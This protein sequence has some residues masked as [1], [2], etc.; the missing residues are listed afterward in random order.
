MH[1]DISLHCKRHTSTF[2]LTKQAQ[3]SCLHLTSSGFIST[4]CPMINLVIQRV[5][6]DGEVP[7]WLGIRRMHRAGIVPWSISVA[8]EDFV[9]IRS[10]ISQLPSLC[11][12]ESHV[13][14]FTWSLPH[15]EGSPVLQGIDPHTCPALTG[16]VN[17]GTAHPCPELLAC[18]ASPARTSPAC[19]CAPVRCCP[20][21]CGRG[22]QSE[23]GPQQGSLLCHLHKKTGD[24][25][26]PLSP[27]PVFLC[28]V[29]LPA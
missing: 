22:R 23:K 11:G 27:A 28:C 2:P 21:C 6:R 9:P 10:F 3:K 24:R 15:G 19:A 7:S 13:L 25:D 20:C 17:V 1:S 12:E 16:A 14:P 5:P 8:V 18:A 29:H 26:F 4:L